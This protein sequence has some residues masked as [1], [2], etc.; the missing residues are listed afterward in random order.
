MPSI[1]CRRGHRRGWPRLLVDRQ[2]RYQDHPLL[3]GQVMTGARVVPVQGGSVG[4]AFL[5]IDAFAGD[6][7]Y[8]Q[9][10]TPASTSG[11]FKEA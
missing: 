10:S 1:N 4:E 8:F 3:V 7:A 2:Q 9:A 6:L 11:E 5:V